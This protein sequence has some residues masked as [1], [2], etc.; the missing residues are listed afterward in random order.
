MAQ[1]GKNRLN[2]K[3]IIAP[4]Y[5]VTCAEVIFSKVG[6]IPHINDL[7]LTKRHANNQY[8]TAQKMKFSLKD[9][10]KKSLIENLIFCDSFR[11][12]SL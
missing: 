7:F 8:Y 1:P 11:P 10:L 9:L 6:S 5:E 12:F 3:K 2:R 4:Y